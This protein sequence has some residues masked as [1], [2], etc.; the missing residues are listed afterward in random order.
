METKKKSKDWLIAILAT[1]IVAA[2]TIGGVL[3]L[4]T[5][6]EKNKDLSSGSEQT[7]VPE[8]ENEVITGENSGTEQNPE[9]QTSQKTEESDEQKTAETMQPAPEQ[10]TPAPQQS[11]PTPEPSSSQQSEQGGSTSEQPADGATPVPTDTPLG[12]NELPD[13]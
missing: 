6:I 13:F 2:V 4:E 3:F 5:Q 12:E 11:T 8:S 9:E 1:F 10:S 7:A